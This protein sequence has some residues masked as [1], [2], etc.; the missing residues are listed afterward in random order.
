MSGLAAELINQAK[1]SD[2]EAGRLQVGADRWL[3]TVIRKVLDK[4]GK[5]AKIGV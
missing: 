3:G 4:P 5:Y 1:K 2:S